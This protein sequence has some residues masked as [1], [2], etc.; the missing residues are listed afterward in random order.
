MLLMGLGPLVAYYAL[1]K[2]YTKWITLRAASPIPFGT[3]LL[4]GLLKAYKF[5]EED[6]Y[7]TDGAPADVQEKR[8][9]GLDELQKQFESLVGPKAAALNEELR[10]LSDIRFTDTNRVPHSFQ[11]VIR[12]KLRLGF[13]SVRSEGPY[14]IDVDGN[15]A[16]DVSGSYGVN[17]AGY[18]MYKR[19]VRRA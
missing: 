6:F 1:N 3:W 8:R 17:V 14:L 19:C 11:P 16:L 13:I 4:S 10:G 15:R 9:K 7:G 2:L 12:S 18:E 5:D